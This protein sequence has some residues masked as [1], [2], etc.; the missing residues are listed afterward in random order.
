MTSI[1]DRQLAWELADQARRRLSDKERMAVF[2]HLG[3]GDHAAPIHR[4]I[5]IATN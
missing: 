4:L 5:D 3:S 2:V 1:M